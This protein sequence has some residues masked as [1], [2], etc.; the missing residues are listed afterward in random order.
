MRRSVPLFNTYLTGAKAP[1]PLAV[2]HSGAKHW[3]NPMRLVRFKIL[4]FTLGLDQL[5]LR[6]T[7]VIAS[8]N[9]KLSKVRRYAPFGDTSGFKRARYHQMSTWMKRIQYQEYY[10]QHLM[11][12][13]VWGLLRKYPPNGTKIAGK[14]DTGYFGYGKHGIHDYT[15]EPL[16]ATAIEMYPRR[17][18]PSP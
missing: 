16:P 3:T 15:R 14:A 10:M 13:H 8:D 7:A 11:I 17:R 12:R 1:H 18:W 9:Y 4:Y 6:R 5:P 2:I